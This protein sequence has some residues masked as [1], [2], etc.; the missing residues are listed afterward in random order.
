[1]GESNGCGTIRG[2]YFVR[3]NIEA[4]NNTL[5][6]VGGGAGQDRGVSLS[7]AQ[8]SWGVSYCLERTSKS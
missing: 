3:W 4:E 8:G 7:R 5:R 6:G 2:W 1:V